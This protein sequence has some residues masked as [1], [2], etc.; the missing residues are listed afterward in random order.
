MKR[1]GLI[2]LGLLAL[3]AVAYYLWPTAPES[4]AMRYSVQGL[5]GGE[6]DD[7]AVADR[8]RAFQFPQDHGAHPEFRSEWWYLTGNLTADDGRRYGFQFTIFR[9]ALTPQPRQG[10][11]QWGTNQVYMAHFAL[12]DIDGERIHT[13]ERF[14]RGALG[15]AGATGDPFRVWLDDWELAADDC[16]DFPWRLQ[17][18]T[19]NIA[20]RLAITSRK[21]VVLQ[22]D[23]GLSQKGPE[24]GNAS[25]YYAYTRL[26]A[27]GELQLQDQHF[28]V[29]GSAWLD[30]E[31]ST[32]L[33]SPEVQGWD[34]FSL[35]LDDGSEL[36]LYQLRTS[37]G[38]VRE[39]GAGAFV[40]AQG[41]AQPLS[42]LDFELQPL[43]HWTSPKT[44]IRYPVQWQARIP[45]LQIELTATA[46]IPDQELDLSVRYWEGAL[47][48]QG[49]RQA[50]PIGGVGY[51]ELTGY[52]SERALRGR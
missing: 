3:A 25:Y 31:W 14:S 46:V 24:P 4:S 12:T 48:I 26:A 28:R 22:G 8:V 36:M 19:E 50:K 29:S 5:L 2:L 1:W 47:D 52:G 45:A 11:S 30:R 34:W 35:Q 41:A 10:R 20:L 16:G 38:I 49:Q 51:M 21:P 43:A 9:F 39:F 18:A 23:R 32:S 15:L 17:V 33:L 13:F 44:R 42:G 27:E 37:D 40:P 6:R 7:Y